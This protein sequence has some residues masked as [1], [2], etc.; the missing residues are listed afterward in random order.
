MIIIPGQYYRCISKDDH[1]D[2]DGDCDVSDGHR[3]GDLVLITSIDGAKINFVCGK[4][5]LHWDIDSFLAN[6]ELDPDGEK[7]REAEIAGLMREAS[8]F[9]SDQKAIETSM[10]SISVATTDLVKSNDPLAAKKKLGM[11][12][13]QIVK[14][15]DA[16]L[17][18]Q[19]RLM[20]FLEEKKA[21]MMAKV[22]AMEAMVK[23]VEEVVWAINIYSGAEEK[24]KRLKKGESAPATE[25]VVV[26]QL[27]LFM[28]HECALFDDE[29]GMD[30][31]NLDAFDDWIKVPAHL[32]QVLPEQRGIVALRV[33]R[34]DKEY[35]DNPWENE[36]R[37]QGNRVTYFLMRN[38]ENLYRIW[39]SLGVGEVLFPRHDEF[40]EIFHGS[41]Q[42]L[43]P[44]TYEY[45]KAMKE[46]D[47]KRRHYMRMVLFLQGLFDRTPIFHPFAVPGVNITNR[48]EC[49]SVITYIHDAEMQLSDGRPKFR[50]WL[51]DLNSTLTV[52]SRIV[53][54]FHSYEF[55]TCK[56]RDGYRGHVRVNP[57]NTRP[58]DYELYTLDSRCRDGF[59]FHFSRG[60]VFRKLDYWQRRDGAESYSES[61]RR[62]SAE[63]HLNDDFI[64][65]FDDLNPADITYYLESRLHRHEYMKLFPLLKR[66]RAMKEKE[67]ADE[68]P[69]VKLLVGTIMSEHKVSQKDAELSV[70]K[71]IQWWKF[72]TRTTRAL[73][74][75]DSKALRMIVDQFGILKRKEDDL[76]KRD[77][78]IQPVV[79]AILAAYPSAAFIGHK[80]ANRFVALIPANDKN[81]FVHE[82]VWRFTR[83]DGVKLYSENKWTLVDSRRDSWRK[84]YSSDRWATWSTKCRMSDVLTDSER[85]KLLAD[86]LDEYAAWLKEERKDLRFMPLA[87]T[88]HKANTLTVWT[89]EEPLIIPKTHIIYQYLHETHIRRVNLEWKRGAAGITFRMNNSNNHCWGSGGDPAD[90]SGKSGWPWN[91]QYQKYP[92]VKLWP[93][94]IDILRK[95]EAEYE[96][97]IERRKKLVDIVDTAVRVIEDK[98]EA[99]REAEEREKFASENDPDLWLKQKEKWHAPQYEHRDELRSLFTGLV[100]LGI[101]VIGKT[102]GWCLD[103]ARG[104]MSPAYVRRGSN[105]SFDEKV[106]A[107]P[108]P[109]EKQLPCLDRAWVIEEVMELAEVRS[110]ED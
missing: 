59:I 4:R 35:S 78:Q 46:A 94:N 60:K 15:K 25:K 1:Q 68:A 8:D 101:P 44:G 83:E 76:R 67:I 17:A 38:G 93:E 81:I 97:Y 58:D 61:K 87:L 71:L 14:L 19:E 41:D 48:E 80:E 13:G 100:D 92:V 55:G 47:A 36:A 22:E 28:D 106:K 3:F 16:V 45:E 51:R 40:D 6:Y 90:N 95:E 107:K 21:L 79:D 64:I 73:N 105:W 98:W 77:K 74:S 39:S 24:I 34:D 102:L 7:K 62:A 75:D 30:G 23:N 49:E 63:I 9:A 96:G 104:K 32:Q 2:D 33:R 85:E 29:G 10:S 66:A 5:R 37:N 99:I 72:K 82:Q 103:Q 43:K 31:D 109:T 65:N 86:G 20:G 70:P 26:R 89:S 54:W 108:L 53:G 27:R 57:E 110:E 42:P 18:K 50:D 91:C 88:E 84:L 12:K 11:A 56:D 52:G 69:F